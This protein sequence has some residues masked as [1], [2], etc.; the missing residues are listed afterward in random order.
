MFPE[1]VDMVFTRLPGARGKP[2]SVY[3]GVG[4]EG[5]IVK[6]LSVEDCLPMVVTYVSHFGCFLGVLGSMRVL[7]CVEPFVC[8]WKFALKLGG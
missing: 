2:T 4:V 3:G 7:D 5:L 1:R 6:R 8:S